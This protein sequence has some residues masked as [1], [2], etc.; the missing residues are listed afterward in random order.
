LT[1]KYSTLQKSHNLSGKTPHPHYCGSH[2]REACVLD[3]IEWVPLLGH[4][5]VLHHRYITPH[6]KIKTNCC[7][8]FLL[9]PLSHKFSTQ[10]HS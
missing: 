4:T 7:S 5:C 2:A 3:Q 1:S 10:Y 9:A 8:Q 6:K